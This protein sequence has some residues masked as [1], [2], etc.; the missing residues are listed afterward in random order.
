VGVFGAI[1]TVGVA[2]A[3]VVAGG[4]A[5]R[6]AVA[7]ATTV[8]VALDEGYADCKRTKGAR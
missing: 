1:V 6:S 5:V 7:D 4:V 3:A 2:D 8:G